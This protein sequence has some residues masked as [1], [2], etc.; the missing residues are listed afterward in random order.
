M[1]DI[2]YS[3][4]MPRFTFTLNSSFEPSWPKQTISFTNVHPLGLLYKLSKR[5]ADD[6]TVSDEGLVTHPEHSAVY[7]M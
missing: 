6:I 5:R 4:L 3:N 2:G 1:H 7:C